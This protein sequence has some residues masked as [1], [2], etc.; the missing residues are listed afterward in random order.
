[1]RDPF[2]LEGNGKGSWEEDAFLA[3]ILDQEEKN[4]ARRTKRNQNHRPVS[5]YSYD[6]TPDEEDF[7]LMVIGLLAVVI[8]VWF[9]IAVSNL[10]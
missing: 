3:Y 2:D 8:V 6:S 10:I 9:L 1:M 7:T 5:R 4:E